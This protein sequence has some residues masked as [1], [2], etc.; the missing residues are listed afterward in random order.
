MN[1]QIVFTNFISFYTPVFAGNEA[2]RCICMKKILLSRLFMYNSL[3]T[4]LQIEDSF[5][6]TNSTLLSVCVWKFPLIKRSILQT[7]NSVFCYDTFNP[8]C[9]HDAQTPQIPFTNSCKPFK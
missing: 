2:D 5:F 1:N 8:A 6:S 7:K 9:D 4:L 3:L